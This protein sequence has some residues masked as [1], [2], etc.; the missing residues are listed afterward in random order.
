MSDF[1]HFLN[2]ADAESLAKLSGISPSLAKS[3]IAARPFE[4]VDDCIKVYGMG[5][6]LLTRAQA[7]F[8]E[9]DGIH[10]ERGLIPVEQPDNQDDIA[11]EKSQPAEEP[12]PTETKPTFGYRLGQALLWFFRTLLRLILIVLIIGG[13][14]AGIYYGV[15][16]VNE[17]LVAP[18]EQNS[19]RVIELENEIKALQLQLTELNN[20][21]NES[22]NRID[23]IER[24]VDAHT[25]SLATLAEMQA[26]LETRL[27]EGNDKTLLALKHE[28]MMT[29]VLDMLARARLYLAQS[30]F[31]LAK[32]DVQSARD[33]LAELQAESNNDILAQA[34][35]RLDMALSNLPEFPIVASGDLEI[36][37]QILVTGES[38]A[39]PTLQPSP[40]PTVTL[41]P[42]PTL[43]AT[44]SATPTP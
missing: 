27:E 21:L 32:D 24:S 15:P 1:L 11:L 40:I 33:L 10:E 7:S 6:V 29:R 2:T 34:G 23:G 14:G 4:S 16:L 22:D 18:V 43:E 44:P 3:L 17:K 41:T 26:A 30:N 37:W 19:A 38:V 28:V 36:A 9:M 42:V 25:A 5:K 39:T 12:S 31:G 13:I 35:V 20:Q 8:E